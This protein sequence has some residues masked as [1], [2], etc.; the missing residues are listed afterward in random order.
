MTQYFVVTH[1]YMYAPIKSFYVYENTPGPRQY[2]ASSLIEF[3]LKCI[4]FP[5][6]YPKI[7]FVVNFQINLRKDSM[8]LS[9]KDLS[10]ELT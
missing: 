2:S 7:K 9:F 5:Q 8:Y 4:V 3:Y 10:L 6:I 1:M